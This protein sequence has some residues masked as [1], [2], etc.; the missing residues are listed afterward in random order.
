[1]KFLDMKNK[2]LIGYCLAIV[3]G[4]VLLVICV[5]NNTQY[6]SSRSK[7]VI[8]VTG[9]FIIAVG[10]IKIRN[11]VLPPLAKTDS[12]SMEEREKDE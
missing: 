3:I 1:M 12:D 6:A 7:I 5:F 4:I 9:C 2:K 10:V 11:T 8:A